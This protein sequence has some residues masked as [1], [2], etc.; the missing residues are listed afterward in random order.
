MNYM[1]LIYT[2]ITRFIGIL[3]YKNALLNTGQ[4]NLSG[5]LFVYD[6]FCILRLCL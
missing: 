4:L 3:V 1:S 6:T 5:I 2:P